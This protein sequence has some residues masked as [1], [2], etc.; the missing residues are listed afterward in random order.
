MKTLVCIFSLSLLLPAFAGSQDSTNDTTKTRFRLTPERRIE[1]RDLSNMKRFGGIVRKENSAFGKVV[2]LNAQKLVPASAFKQTLDYFDYEIHPL[3]E[4]KDV[5]SVNLT[6]PSA[7]I[8]KAG[9]KVGVV[10]GESADLPALLVAPELGWAVVN[11]AALKAGCK[12]NETLAARARKELMRAFALAGGASFMARGAL[13]L[14]PGVRTPADLDPLPEC[15]YGAEVRYALQTGL[16]GYGVTPWKQVT[17]K[18]ACQEGWAHSPTNEYQQ[19][20]WDRIHKLPSNPMKIEFDP[21][22]GE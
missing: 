17:Y 9:G 6:N 12:D 15:S 19:K 5:A 1:R 22:K 11:V 13:V 2:F 8:A 20:I 21:K 10:L 4:M 18:Q 16:P 3:M 7:D 14:E